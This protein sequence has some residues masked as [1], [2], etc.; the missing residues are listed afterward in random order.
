MKTAS[1]DEFKGLLLCA[2]LGWIGLYGCEKLDQHMQKMEEVGRSL[3]KD[4]ISKMIEDGEVP[5]RTFLR[6]KVNDFG[7]VKLPHEDEKT[8]C[9]VVD[10]HE[11]ITS[12]EENETLFELLK[13]AEESR[14][15]VEVRTYQYHL[16]QRRNLEQVLFTNSGKI[17]SK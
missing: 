12:F 17:V 3:V 2:W 5:M 11:V 6:G 14:E 10:Y 4:K 16:S 9:F 8:L 13:N 15:F 7:Y 1:Y